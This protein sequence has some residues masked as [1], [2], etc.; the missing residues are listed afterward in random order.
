MGITSKMLSCRLKELVGEGLITWDVEAGR[1]P[2]KS[3]Y[4]LTESWLET[5]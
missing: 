2:V 5:V 1:L 3:E 4:T